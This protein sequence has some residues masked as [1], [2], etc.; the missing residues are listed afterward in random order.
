MPEKNEE[1]DND[2]DVDHAGRKRDYFTEEELLAMDGHI[3]T[4]DARTQLIYTLFKNTGL[5]MNALRNLKVSGVWNSVLN[6]PLEYGHAAEKR[7]TTRIF[8][9]RR[10]EHLQSCLMKY[11]QQNPILLEAKTFLFPAIETGL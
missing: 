4:M 5:R 9:I 7:K 3:G 10:D 6:I 11:I 1:V 2:A 8:A